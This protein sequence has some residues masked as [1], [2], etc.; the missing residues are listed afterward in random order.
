[1]KVIS[2]LEST[3]PENR[4]EGVIYLSQYSNPR[5]QDIGY[6]GLSF[7]DEVRREHISPSE[8]AWDFA[9]FALSI[10][11]ID[12]LISRNESPDGWTRVIDAE[13]HLYTPSIWSNLKEELQRLLRFLTGDFWLLDFQPNGSKP[14]QSTP[15]LKDADCISLLSGGVD[16]LIGG[17]DLTEQGRKPLFVS[18]I[19][20]GSK[21]AQTNYSL[22]LNAEERH[23]QWSF[24]ASLDGYRENST[25]GRSMV[26]YAFAA[27]AS[28]VI[29]PA[30]NQ[31]IDLYIPENGFIS[32][33]IPL[34]PARFGS[35]STKTT[36]PVYMDGLQSLWRKLNI[37]LTLKFPYRFKTKG[38]MILECLN[39]N[40]L[41]ELIA[42]SV[43]CGKYIRHY[44]HCGVCVPCLVRRGS[45]YKSGLEDPTY[46]R[47]NIQTELNDNI[48]V[49][50]T[51]Y[52]RM[53][54][55]GVR[56]I[57]GSELIFAQG[58]EKALY[59]SV[60]SRGLTEIYELLHFYG[61]V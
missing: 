33:N 59:E 3:I 36:H 30:Q 18:Q 38:E 60:F 50:A 56:S 34:S 52:L 37:P 32:L 35:L 22:R 2:C 11:A 54:S 61:R 17:I 41:Q 6:F 44:E 7:R 55:K 49:A 8:N 21:S 42:E 15:V 9:T 13:I 40:L 20:Q 25:R 39:K 29:I 16:S 58:N 5:K 4:P 45:F 53:N 23:F 12:K 24:E 48:S 47:K 31:T 19:V 51:A 27:V 57:I 14:P 46:Y 26:F 10:A 1:M 28:S 43:S